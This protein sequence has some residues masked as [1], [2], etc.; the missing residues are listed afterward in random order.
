MFQYASSFNQPVEAWDTSSVET[1]TQTTSRPD[2]DG[3]RCMFD[4]A[5]SFTQHPTWLRG[6]GGWW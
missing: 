4:R 5:D 1:E 2:P 3:M 6:G